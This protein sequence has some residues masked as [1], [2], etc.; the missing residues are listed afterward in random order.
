MSIEYHHGD[1]KTYGSSVLRYFGD[2]DYRVNRSKGKSN[3]EIKDWLHANPSKWATGKKNRAGGGGWYDELERGIIAD[4]KAAEQQRLQAAAEQKRLQDAADEQARLDAM[5]QQQDAV[6]DQSSPNYGASGS[7]GVNQP[8]IKKPTPGT[9]DPNEFAQGYMN[10]IMD[11]RKN[12]QS[13]TRYDDLLKT[14]QSAS[15]GAPTDEP[16]GP[17]D[18]QRYRQTAFS[19]DDKPMRYGLN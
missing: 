10:K 6:A 18:N 19:Y 11:A 1:H 15:P 14:D 9:I 16:K 5:K 7:T 13:A 12:K 17:Y 8:A 4:N 3:Q 2:I